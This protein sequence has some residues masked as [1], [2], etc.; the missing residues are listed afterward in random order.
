[1]SAVPHGPHRTPIGIAAAHTSGEVSIEEM[2]VGAIGV[3]AEIMTVTEQTPPVLEILFEVAAPDV[4]ELPSVLKEATVGEWT[5]FVALSK[6]TQTRVRP[7]D[8]VGNG[9][10]AAPAEHVS[11]VAMEEVVLVHPG[12]CVLPCLSFDH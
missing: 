7:V 5:E 12:R 2:G 8:G 10:I 1:M 11:T 4:V 3:P 9:V 6:G